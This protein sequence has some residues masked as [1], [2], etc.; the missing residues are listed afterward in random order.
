MCF[1]FETTSSNFV[2]CSHHGAMTLEDSRQLRSFLKDYR[3]KLLVELD[4]ASGPDLVRE[5]CRLRA[6]L[7]QTACVGPL[8]SRSLCRNLPGKDYYM[9]EVRHFTSETEALAWLW[10]PETRHWPIQQGAATVEG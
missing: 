5:L 10:Q 9:H 2:R 3:G 1:S 8:H 4:D 7:P 6:M